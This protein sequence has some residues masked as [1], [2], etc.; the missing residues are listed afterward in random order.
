MRASTRACRLATDTA[1]RSGVWREA[2]ALAVDMRPVKLVLISSNSLAPLVAVMKSTDAGQRDDLGR[3]RGRWRHGPSIW[4]ILAQPQ[5]ASV[6]VIIA[7]VGSNKSHEMAV[8]GDHH[9]RE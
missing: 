1:P 7:D 4:S 2:F 3:G 6:L 9:L 5:V 8:A